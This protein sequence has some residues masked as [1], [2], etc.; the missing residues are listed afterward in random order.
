MCVYNN[1]LFTAVN[2]QKGRSFT[3]LRKT[4]EMHIKWLDDRFGQYKS[5]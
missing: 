5:S 1:Y 3:C 4:F 2:F